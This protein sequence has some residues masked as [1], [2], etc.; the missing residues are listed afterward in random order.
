MP[1]E[2]SA[3]PPHPAAETAAS[4]DA[5]SSAR[6]TAPPARWPGFLFIIALT[7]AAYGL[8][9]LPFPPF[10]IEQAGQIRRPISPEILA[11]LL[12]LLCRNLLPLPAFVGPASKWTVR[13]ILP[14]T[15]VL[16]GATLNLRSFADDKLGLGGLGIISC[17][18]VVAALTAYFVGRALGL[19]PHTAVLI[20]AGTAICGNSA[21]I[22]VAPIVKARDDELVLS[23][24]TINLMGLIVM[25]AL[26]AIA[27]GLH[28]SDAAA[29]VWA[30]ATVHAVPQAVAAGFAFSPAAGAVA[31]LT[32][33]VRVALLAPFVFA[34]ALLQ[35]H[36]KLVAAE[37]EVARTAWRNFLPWYVW[38]F[39]LIALLNTFGLLPAIP[40]PWTDNPAESPISSARLIAECGKILLTV[41]MT[42]IGL[43]VYLRS[44]LHVG[45]RA[46]LTGLIAA[47]TLCGVTYGLIVALIA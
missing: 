12:G 13:T 41:A 30:G 32:K 16:L 23:L 15:V 3:E 27:G 20:G 22:A 40:L 9:H 25:L 44:L 21:V 5:P 18:I 37:H 47:V 6:P 1:R 38:G 17:G 24:G 45:A 46:V 34:L 28:L 39:F 11:I 4:P 7:A 33:V 2:S 35:A 31:T 29:G 42:A 8:H 14:L 36:G 19:T 10:A 26:P 43:E